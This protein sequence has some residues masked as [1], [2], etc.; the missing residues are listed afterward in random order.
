M[1]GPEWENVSSGAKNLITKMLDYNPRTR[2]S[3]SE[4]IQ[5]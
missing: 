1:K 2:I 4:A 3:A 5:D